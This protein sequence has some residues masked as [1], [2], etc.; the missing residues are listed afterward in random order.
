MLG[1]PG[2]RCSQLEGALVC[3]DTGQAAL[4]QVQRR[5][6]GLV[7]AREDPAEGLPDNLPFPGV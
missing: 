5:E 4:L 3:A 1:Y 6:A 2:P 7:S